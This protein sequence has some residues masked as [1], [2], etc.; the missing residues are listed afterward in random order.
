MGYGDIAI[1][2]YLNDEI[3]AEQNFENVQLP[4]TGDNK[5]QVGYF[6][7]SDVESVFNGEID[8]LSIFNVDRFKIAQKSC[9]KGHLLEGDINK[10]C[11][12]DLLD[13]SELCSQW[14]K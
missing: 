11:Y 1:K 8:N 14:L 3:Y 7:T 2:L 5:L 10:D 13:L 12:V 4:A 9:Q 6:S